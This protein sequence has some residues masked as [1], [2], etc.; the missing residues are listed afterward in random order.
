MRSKPGRL[1]IDSPRARRTPQGLGT[2]A[3]SQFNPMLNLI[4]SLDRDRLVA[5]GKLGWQRIKLAAGA[6]MMLDWRP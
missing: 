5:V 3:L 4:A 1:S 6:V 2:C